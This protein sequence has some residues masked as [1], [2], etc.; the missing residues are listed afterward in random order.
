MRSDDRGYICGQ[1]SP[2]GSSCAAR[3]RNSAIRSVGAWVWTMATRSS[4]P[5]AAS[6][7]TR[8]F[9]ARSCVRTLSVPGLPLCMVK[10]G[11]ICNSV[12]KPSHVFV[13]PPAAFQKFQRIQG[14][15]DMAALDL[16]IERG[17]DF[18]N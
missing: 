9:M 16:S 11:L 3:E 15:K 4:G 10:M 13:H 1:I 14:G 12:A 7:S 18:S 6:I 5:T 2:S 17:Q 8:R